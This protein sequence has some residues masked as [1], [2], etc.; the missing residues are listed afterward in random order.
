[1]RAVEQSLGAPGSPL[2]LVSVVLQGSLKEDII[3]TYISTVIDL[4]IKLS[5]LPDLDPAPEVNAI[6]GRLVD[7]CGQTPNEIITERVLS[8]PFH[9]LK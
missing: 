6:F 8:A 1:M 5:K 3:E 9:S 4:Y 7:I 2:P